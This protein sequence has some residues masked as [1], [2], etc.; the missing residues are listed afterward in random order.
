MEI[1]ENK[2]KFIAYVVA[3]NEENISKLEELFNSVPGN[4]MCEWHFVDFN[5]INKIPALERLDFLFLQHD[6]FIEKIIDWKAIE[7]IVSE[8]DQIGIYWMLEQ[9]KTDSW[10]LLD[11]GADDIIEVFHG[12]TWTTHKISSLIRRTDM[13]VFPPT[14]IKY[15]VFS[16]D[17]IDKHCFISGKKTVLTSKELQLLILLIRHS[18]CRIHHNGEFSGPDADFLSRNYIYKSIWHDISGKDSTRV[19]DQLIFKL[20][21]KIGSNKIEIIKNSGVRLNLWNEK[22]K[23]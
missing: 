15:D 22:K 13:K 1:E 19:V 4:E 20:K 23:S 10:K 12:P 14:I 2:S 3:C 7:K 18:I 11:D 8:F 16:I 9:D 5:F 6:E 21:N 17:L